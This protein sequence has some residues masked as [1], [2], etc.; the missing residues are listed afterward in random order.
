[1]HVTGVL[2]HFHCLPRKVIQPW[3]S[4]V[5]S[6]GLRIAVGFGGSS[7][8]VSAHGGNRALA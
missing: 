5:G 2:V 3:I 6:F 1:M 8:V 4:S 7:Q